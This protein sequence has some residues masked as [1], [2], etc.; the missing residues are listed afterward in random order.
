MGF[1]PGDGSPEAASMVQVSRTMFSAVKR[2]LGF[3]EISVDALP[4]DAGNRLRKSQ[5][6]GAIEQMRVFVLGNTFFAPVLAMQAWGV[7]VTDCEARGLPGG[8][9]PREPGEQCCSSLVF[10]VSPRAASNRNMAYPPVPMATTAM[11]ATMNKILKKPAQNS[12]L[13]VDLLRLL[14]SRTS[15]PSPIV[16]SSSSSSMSTS[17]SV[18]EL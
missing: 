1:V 17:R 11:T 2:V 10:T 7:G 16:S 14:R 13:P 12:S 4:T 3:D 15:P 9:D 5:I 18:S 6:R 8:V